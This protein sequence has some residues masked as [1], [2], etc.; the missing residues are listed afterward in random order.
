M[1]GAWFDG[2]VPG[3]C[4]QLGHRRPCP[5]GGEDPAGSHLGRSHCPREGKAPDRR[6][7]RCGIC[8]VPSSKTLWWNFTA[9]AREL[10][11]MFCFKAP[12]PSKIC[13]TFK[14]KTIYSS[15]IF[16]FREGHVD[17]ESS[18]PVPTPLCPIKLRSIFPKMSSPGSVSLGCLASFAPGIALA[19][20]NGFAWLSGTHLKGK[21]CLL[22]SNL[23]DL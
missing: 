6:G 12:L 4:P 18:S 8:V 10:G 20:F 19:V 16:I 21:M 3:M 9:Q 14:F 23:E 7:G 11:P 22:A 13:V 2:L 17:T 5:G 15:C 1:L